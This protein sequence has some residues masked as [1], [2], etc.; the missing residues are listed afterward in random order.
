MNERPHKGRWSQF[1]LRTLRDK[2]WR[3]MIRHYGEGSPFVRKCKTQFRNNGTVLAV[4]SPAFLLLALAAPSVSE[5]LG[6][7]AVVVLFGAGGL[8]GVY[9]SFWSPQSDETDDAQ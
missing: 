2:Y 6:W 9:F 7:C 1:S 4:I 8:V 3:L 5:K